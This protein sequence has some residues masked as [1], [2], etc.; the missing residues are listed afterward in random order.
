ML[1]AALSL[2]AERG[3]ADL[4]LREVARRAGVT[5][6]APYHHFADKTALL[7]AVAR[8]GFEG[9]IVALESAAA[10]R[11]TLESELLAMTQAY[12]V[13]A[14]E[15]PAH[16]RVM[17]LPD[18]KESP[19][20]NE[21]HVSANRAFGL[22]VARVARARND[23]PER[24]QLELATTVW[25]ALHGLSLLAIDGTLQH[26]LPE[27]DAFISRACRFITGMIV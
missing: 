27:S 19:E 13:F 1:R 18:V 4:S 22:L 10:R 12:V 17:F 25:A 8:E 24:A 21:M 7:A 6:A 5:Y 3:A 14:L 26:K 2:L 16:Y 9:L 23:Q 20:A 11:K 15:N